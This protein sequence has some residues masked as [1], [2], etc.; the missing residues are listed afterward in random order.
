MK[1]M[2]S[3]VEKPQKFPIYSM[4][5]NMDSFILYN[6]ESDKKEIT[7]KDLEY[8]TIDSEN[9]F[10][11]SL[12]HLDLDGYVNRLGASAGVCIHN[13]ENNHAEGHACI[14]KFTCINNMAEYEALILG[15]QLIG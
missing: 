1:F 11:E 4:H 12:C 3:S 15:L 14:L 5:S 8:K 13:M 2:V 10:H 7:A 6:V 9:T